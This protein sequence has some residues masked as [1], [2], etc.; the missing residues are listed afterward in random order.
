MLFETILFVLLSP[1]VLLTLPAVGK[2]FFMTN[3]T[4][5]LSVLVHAVI[6][7][8]ILYAA[9]MYYEKR[10][11]FA[12][13]LTAPGLDLNSEIGKKVIVLFVGW[14]LFVI[15]T[16]TNMLLNYLTPTSGETGINPMRMIVYVLMIV[17]FSLGLW[18][19]TI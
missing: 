10:E 3:R 8:S 6:F 4:S 16:I 2:G 13:G 19:A 11:G 7:G 15:T 17:A 9:S 18:G 14:L 1:G 12:I 5:T